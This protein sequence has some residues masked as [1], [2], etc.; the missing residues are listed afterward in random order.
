[1]LVS[2]KLEGECVK[3]MGMIRQLE[4]DQE[5]KQDEIREVTTGYKNMEDFGDL[6]HSF[7]GAAGKETLLEC[8][9]IQTVTISLSRSSAA[10]RK[11]Q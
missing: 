6:E 1:M 4:C 10:K 8:Q 3:K 7:R 5:V 2:Q 9:E 11:E